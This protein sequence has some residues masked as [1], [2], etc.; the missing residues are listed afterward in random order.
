MVPKLRIILY[1]ALVP[2]V[3]T[4]SYCDGETVTLNNSTV[5]MSAGGKVFSVPTQHLAFLQPSARISPLSGATG[6]KELLV[7]FSAAWLSAHIDGYQPILNMGFEGGAVRVAAGLQAKRD[8]SRLHP[9]TV[10]LWYKRGAY[11]KRIIMQQREHNT[12]FHIIQPIPYKSRPF[13]E[14]E[15]WHLAEKL[16]D[17]SKPYPDEPRWR[18]YLC[19]RTKGL[20]AEA[21]VFTRCNFTLQAANDIFFD[22]SLSSENLQVRE[23]VF[24]VIAEEINSWIIDKDSNNGG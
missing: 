15:Q 11:K 10:D 14:G 13:N 1:L 4:L 19:S 6:G 7:H 2:A 5:E 18:P 23:A 12:G 21:K 8:H 22:I 24:S 20:I 16:P 9:P 17:E 3:I